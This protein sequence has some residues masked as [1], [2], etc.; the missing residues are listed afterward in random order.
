M[1]LFSTNFDWAVELD[2]AELRW[3]FNL[4]QYCLHPIGYH[5]TINIERFPKEYA[6][7]HAVYR[8]LEQIKCAE[9]RLPQSRTDMREG[10]PLLWEHL[11]NE[12][13]QK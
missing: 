11:I 3:L 6:V 12:T 10:F 9:D 7:L 8:L 4:V 1:V 2:P 5:Q 13:N